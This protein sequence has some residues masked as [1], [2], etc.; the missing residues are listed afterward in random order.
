MKAQLIFVDQYG[1]AKCI[2]GLVERCLN[3]SGGSSKLS[4][5]GHA[6][7]SKGVERFSGMHRVKV[8]DAMALIGT[9]DVLD[10]AFGINC[11]DICGKFVLSSHVTWEWGGIYCEHCAKKFETVPSCFEC[12][13]LCNFSWSD[14]KFGEPVNCGC[15]K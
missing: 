5:E 6:A 9:L 2:T 12:G 1:N 3:M 15:K 8:M 11:C 4:H 10:D 14:V 7:I 13:R